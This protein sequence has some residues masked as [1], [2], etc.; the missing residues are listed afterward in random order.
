M[1]HLYIYFL[2]F[3]DLKNEL[4]QRNTLIDE[5]SAK[6]SCQRGEQMSIY[7][8]LSALKQELIDCKYQVRFG[9]TR[10]F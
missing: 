1:V 7:R 3:D 5:M 10:V 8:N 2:Q 6:E 9:E 4:M